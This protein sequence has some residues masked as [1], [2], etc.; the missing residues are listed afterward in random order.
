MEEEMFLGLRKTDG[1]S[2]TLF[3]EKFGQ[4]LNSVYGQTIQYLIDKGLIE[5]NGDRVQL[6]RNGV[7]RG[8]KYFNNF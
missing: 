5:Q 3:Q 7:F 2:A 4:S 1:V 6:T 8:M